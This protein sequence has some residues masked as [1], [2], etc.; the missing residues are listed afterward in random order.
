[1]T[2]LL[3]F[4]S[5]LILMLLGNAYAS[6]YNNEV[7]GKIAG[8]ITR[9]NMPAAG[10]H[11]LSCKDWSMSSSAPCQE[12][13]RAVTDQHGQFTFDKFT[14]LKAADTDDRN[15][16]LKC[17]NCDPGWSIWFKVVDGNQT[18]LFWTGGLGYG[19][20]F[21][22]VTCDLASPKNIGGGE[23]DCTASEDPQDSTQK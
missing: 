21:A 23:L 9:G 4:G 2:R 6:A 18:R 8:T 5:S 3:T 16:S 14:G 17:A 20:P 15:A 13:I 10:L 7:L 12:P 1:M 19:R 11:I 22:R